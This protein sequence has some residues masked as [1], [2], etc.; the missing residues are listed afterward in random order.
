MGPKLLHGFIGTYRKTKKPKNENADNVS[1]M[2]KMCSNEPQMNPY[3]ILDQID[4]QLTT[5]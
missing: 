2:V 3:D 5:P 4:S 1:I